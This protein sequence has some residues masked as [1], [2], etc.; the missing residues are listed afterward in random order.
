M[1][2][3]INPS[4]TVEDE[5]KLLS[6]LGLAMRAGAVT[7]G[8]PL[9]CAALQKGAKSAPKLVFCASDCSDNTKKRISDRCAFYGVKLVCLSADCGTLGAAMGKTSAVAALAL[10]DEGFCRL[11]E[12]YI[13]FAL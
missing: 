2:E 4:A 13:R 10:T 1:S 3:I 12:K 11:A 9:I 8:V 7:V 5:A 6:S